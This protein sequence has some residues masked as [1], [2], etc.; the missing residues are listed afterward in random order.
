MDIQDGRFIILKKL[1]ITTQKLHCKF[2]GKE[3]TIGHREYLANPF[4]NDREC[5]QKRLEASG[6]VD[7]ENNHKIIDLG[8]GY[9]Q[10]EPIDKNKLFRAR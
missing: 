4:C 9:I 1:K 10:I 2:C 8:N 6:S 7:L 5:F 3:L